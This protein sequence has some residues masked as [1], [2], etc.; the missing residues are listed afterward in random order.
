MKSTPSSLSNPHILE[1]EYV[2]VHTTL[3]LDL[4][5]ENLTHALK[6][7]IFFIEEAMKIM[8]EEAMQ[9]TSTETI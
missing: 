7:F 8:N 2:C 5:I 4:E 9:I 6:T 3:R 1:L